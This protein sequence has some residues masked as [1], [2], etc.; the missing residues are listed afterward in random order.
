LEKE[1]YIYKGEKYHKVGEV[2]CGGILKIMLLPE[3]IEHLHLNHEYL[4][5]VEETKCR[6][7]E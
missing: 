5:L 4:I 2:Y 3:R 1:W 7:E 6:K